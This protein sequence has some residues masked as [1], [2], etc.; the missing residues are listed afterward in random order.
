VKNNDTD[1]KGNNSSSFDNPKDPRSLE[2]KI[3]KLKR[4]HYFRYLSKCFAGRGG[5]P[6]WCS[7]EGWTILLFA[8]ILSISSAVYVFRMYIYHSNRHEYILIK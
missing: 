2:D 3:A 5:Y 6:A 7:F 1:V 8:A 4:E